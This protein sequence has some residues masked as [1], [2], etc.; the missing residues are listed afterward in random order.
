MQ[1]PREKWYHCE[2][3]SPPSALRLLHT[4]LL[5]ATRVSATVSL[6]ALIGEHRSRSAV[7]LAFEL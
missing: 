7:F 2:A 4:T 1:A 3:A 5:H 6:N